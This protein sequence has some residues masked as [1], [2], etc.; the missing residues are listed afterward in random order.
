VAAKKL[1]HSFF[2]NSPYAERPAG[3]RDY[4]LVLEKICGTVRNIS[5]PI[6]KRIAFLG[7]ISIP[8]NIETVSKQLLNNSSVNW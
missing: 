8:Y 2:T 1:P 3:C 4:S 7:P 5:A 6:Q